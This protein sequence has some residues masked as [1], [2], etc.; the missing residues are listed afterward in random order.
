MDAC[1]HYE[2]GST[3]RIAGKAAGM[4]TGDT[5]TTAWSRVFPMAT[6]SR[7]D[8]VDATRRRAPFCSAAGACGTARV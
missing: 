8:M 1:R 7:A 6:L 4:S 2:P 5:D 3:R